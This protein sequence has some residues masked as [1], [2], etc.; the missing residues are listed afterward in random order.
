MNNTPL[1]TRFTAAIAAARITYALLQ[2]LAPL[3][4]AA[5]AHV[6]AK[7]Q[8]GSPVPALSITR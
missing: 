6:P 2:V 7:A 5:M 1:R 3:G 4:G 8:P